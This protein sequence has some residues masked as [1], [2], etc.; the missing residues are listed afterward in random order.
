M[1]GSYAGSWFT[2]LAS[3]EL[4]PRYEPLIHTVVMSAAVVFVFTSAMPF[5]PGAEIGFGL[6]MVFGS[7]IAMLVYLCM[8]CSLLIAFVAGRVI[9]A[10]YIAKF[11]R[12]LGFKR[13]CELVS[14][15]D[16]LDSTER[17]DLL[18]KNAPRRIVPALLRH[19]YLALMVFFN[20]PGNSVLGGGG[21][22]AFIAG[23]SGLFSFLGFMA[24]VCV[25]IAPIPL[26][27]FLAG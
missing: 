14:Q 4:R 2:E 22:I 1:A 3:I 25:A 12:F 27:F 24:A 16:A 19:R 8:V 13:A 11:F 21:G 26:F 6:L 10:R 20:M 23:I 17:L 5:V 15:L 7:R 9:P 18:T